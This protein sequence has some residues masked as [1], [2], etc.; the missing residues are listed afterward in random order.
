MKL[1]RR[2]SAL[3]R[4]LL[5]GESQMFGAEMVLAAVLMPFLIN[6]AIAWAMPAAIATS[7]AE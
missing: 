7:F 2:N 4:E 1:N 6:A 5:S 3:S